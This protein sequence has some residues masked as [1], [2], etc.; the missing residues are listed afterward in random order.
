MVNINIDVILCDLNGQVDKMNGH[1]NQHNVQKTVVVLECLLLDDDGCVSFT[2]TQFPN[3]DDVKNMF[4]I[5][6]QYIFLDLIELN[7]ILIR[8]VD[9]IYLSSINLKT[10]DKISTCIDESNKLVNLSLS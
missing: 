8:Y 7:V 10:F 5:F 4:S 1:V 9:V 6:G 2:N 3:D